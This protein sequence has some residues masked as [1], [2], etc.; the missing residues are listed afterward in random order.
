[1]NEKEQYR[2]LSRP[3][4]WNERILNPWVRTHWRASLVPAAAVLPAPIA[5]FKVAA[6]KKLVVGCREWA[7]GP[8][9]GVLLSV[10]YPCLP[11]LPGCPYL[12]SDGARSVFFGKNRV[13]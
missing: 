7:G 5:Y 13:L 12:V 2:S 6:V 4:N 11:A 8:L 9:R 1:M 3:C 10:P